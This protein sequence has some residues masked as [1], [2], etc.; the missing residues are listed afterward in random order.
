MMEDVDHEDE[1][2]KI[3]RYWLCVLYVYNSI[4]E[5]C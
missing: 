2:S 4:R 5:L 1:V 3:E